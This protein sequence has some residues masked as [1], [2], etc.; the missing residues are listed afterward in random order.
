M[1]AKRYTR[2]IIDSGDTIIAVLCLL[3][4]IGIS[5]FG[6]LG[7]SFSLEQNVFLILS[8][9]PLITFMVFSKLRRIEKATFN[10]SKYFDNSEDV[11]HE[12]M[13]MCRRANSFIYATG[14][15]TKQPLTSCLEEAV[16]GSEIT[17]RRFLTSEVDIADDLKKHI[18]IMKEVSPNAFRYQE[19]PNCTSFMVTE[20]QVMIIMPMPESGNF[21]G[22]L[23]TD[24]NAVLQYTDY[25]NKL[26]FEEGQ[27]Y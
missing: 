27:P 12:L 15:R 14:S 9:L 22:V 24:A 21:R 26:F 8:L 1:K 20:K 10:K 18:E 16:I 2:A 7:I 13:Q 6:F 25:F 23:V 4:C 19:M 17:Y 11:I 3:T 5:L